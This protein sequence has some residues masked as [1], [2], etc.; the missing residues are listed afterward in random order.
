MHLSSTHTPRPSPPHPSYSPHSATAHLESE[1]SSPLQFPK[2]THS[3]RSQSHRPCPEQ[4]R[5]P[6][7]LSSHPHPYPP[8]LHVSHRA[9]SKPAAHTHAPITHSP[10]PAPPHSSSP[11]QPPS[12]SPEHVAPDHPA[13]H[14][15]PPLDP[16][17]RPCPEQ[18]VTPSHSV[19]H[20]Y[21]YIE[22][23][24]GSHRSP[25]NPEAHSQ[26][27]FTHRPTPIP[28]QS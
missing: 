8:L 11:P 2:H 19:P 14:T 15:H 26:L 24:Q 25:T 27:P 21:P 9:P 10:R 23:A 20:E 7:H 28:P 12:P 4:F 17:Q 13:E 16:L 5:F 18:P 6:P 22:A 1:Q 3:P